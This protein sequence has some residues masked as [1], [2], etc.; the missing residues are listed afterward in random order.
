MQTA[1]PVADRKSYDL[2]FR[3]GAAK[4]SW[5][6]STPGI[7]LSEDAIVWTADGRE[8]QARLGDIAEIHLQTG[9]VGRNMIASCRLRCRD[10]STLLIA[11]NNGY[12]LQD[13]AHDKAYRAFVQDLHARLAARKDTQAAFT[14]GFSAARYRFGKVVIVVA[15]LFFLVTPVVLLLITGAWQMI[16]ALFLG[17]SLL[18]PVYRVMRADAPRIYDP[19]QVPPE[20][21]PTTSQFGL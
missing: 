3:S 6:N 2:Y 4:F 17:V 18:W 19:R 20:L 1:S 7:S 14:S 10:G 12:G 21:M 5:R 9:S 11:S 8:Q 15:G 13:D 16:W